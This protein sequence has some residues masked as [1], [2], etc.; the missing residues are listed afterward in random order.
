MSA[1]DQHY[2]LDTARPPEIDQRVQRRARGPSRIQH[3][4][5]Q[6]NLSL[7]DRKRNFVRR[8]NGCGPTA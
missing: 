7:V 5:D 8:T 1:V 6:E 4:V 2:E 3:V